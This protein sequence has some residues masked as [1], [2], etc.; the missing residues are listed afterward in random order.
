MPDQAL[1]EAHSA[2]LAAVA[3]HSAEWPAE[4]EVA[5]ESVLNSKAEWLPAEQCLPVPGAPQSPGSVKES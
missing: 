4:P 5:A 1:V 3:T 2:V